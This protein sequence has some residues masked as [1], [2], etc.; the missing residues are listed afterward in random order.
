MDCSPSN[1]SVHGDSPGRNTAVG[2]HALLHGI[3]QT[4]V[5]HIAGG[6]FTEP[7]GKPKNTGEGSLSLL[8]RIFTTQKANQGSLHCRWILYQLS[9][10]GSPYLG[11]I[12]K[13]R[14]TTLPI[15][16]CIVKDMI[17]PVFMCG[18]ESWTIRKTECWRI[19]AFIL[20]CW[21]RVPWTARRSN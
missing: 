12:L 18:C 11:S 4:Q 15:K 8:Q 21:R 19:D 1:T 3:F 17:F 2:C 6:F 14:D 16:V 13:S 9:Y 20:R 10:Q 5:S 7:L